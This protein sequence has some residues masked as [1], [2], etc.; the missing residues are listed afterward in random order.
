MLANKDS[1]GVSPIDRFGMTEKKA[2]EV[3]RMA[4]QVHSI[5]RSMRINQVQ[6]YWGGA[7]ILVIFHNYM[8]VCVYVTIRPSVNY[9]N[10]RSCMWASPQQCFTFS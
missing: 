3:K 4:T 10:K 6:N 9:L 2:H 1:N 7:P 8:C 5:A